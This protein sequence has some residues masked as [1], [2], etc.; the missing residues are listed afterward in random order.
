MGQ[1]E[2]LLQ[3]LETRHKE[4]AGQIAGIGFIWPG[5]IQWRWKVCGKPN[6]ACSKDPAARHG[7]YPYW[8]TKVNGKTVN[9]R[10][11]HDEAIL[12]EKWIRNRRE[13]ESIMAEMKIVSDQALSIAVKCNVPRQEDP[14]PIP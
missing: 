7:P 4:L 8:T 14:D 2:L 3:T 5:S 10:L 6:C 11:G 12:I 13:I 9:R 1:D